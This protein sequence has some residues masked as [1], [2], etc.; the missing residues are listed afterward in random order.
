MSD[1][2]K[3]K[4]ALFMVIRNST[5]MPAGLRLNKTMKE[6]NQLS[7]ETMLEVL[8]MIDF[9][10]AA[11]SYS[12]GKKAYYDKLKGAEQEGAIDIINRQKAEIERLQNEN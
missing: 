3:Y 2:K 12:Q 1:E 9:E 11:K 6:V 8:K 5:V 7:Y 10:N 4:I